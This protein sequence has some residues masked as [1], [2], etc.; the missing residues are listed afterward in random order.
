[1]AT[2]TNNST[3]SILIKVD[4][5]KLG[6]RELL[7]KS[8]DCV[9]SAVKYS[10]P[11]QRSFRLSDDNKMRMINPDNY[12]KRSQ[13]FEET[14]HVACKLKAPTCFVSSPPLC[15]PSGLS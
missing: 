7:D 12:Y 9:F 5:I 6:L 2:G 14:F 13:D 1:M 11:I 15:G 8:F 3:P 10:Y 4:K